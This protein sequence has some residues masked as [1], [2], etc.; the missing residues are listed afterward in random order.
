MRFA[1]YPIVRAFTSIAVVHYALLCASLQVC[2][3]EP[4]AGQIVGFQDAKGK[5]LFLHDFK[6]KPVLINLWASWCAPCVKEM[7]SLA[8][9]QQDYGRQRALWS[10]H[11]RRT[12]PWRM[13]PISTPR[14]ASPPS[15]LISTKATASGR[16]CIRAGCPTV[17]VTRDGKMV[18]RIEG[19][20]DWQA[21]QVQAM[22]RRNHREMISLVRCLS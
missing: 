19:P 12:I 7:P 21:P 4:A 9:L 16:R 3:A 10:S 5:V 1:S 14:T 17:L 13:R 22:L 2:A 6:G 11:C 15:P 8:K 18:Q 20:V